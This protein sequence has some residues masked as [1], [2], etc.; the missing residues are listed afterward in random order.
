[1]FPA[2]EATMPKPS[3]ITLTTYNVVCARDPKLLMALRAMADINTDIALLTETKLCDERYAKKGHGYTVF[4]TRA[5]STQQGGVAFAWKT[6]GTHWTLEGMRAVTAN[7]VSATLVSGTH[8]WLVIGAYLPPSCSP[9]NELTAIEAEYRRSPRLPVIWLGDFNANL[10]DDLCERAIAISTTAQHLGVV[11]MLHLFPQKKYRKHTFHRHLADGAHQRSRCDYI[12][13]DPTMEV[14]SLRMVDPPRYHS[15]HVALKMQFH[16]STNQAHRRY[17]NNRSQLPSVQAAADEGEPNALFNQLLSHH[18]RPVVP[19]Y[20]TRD[21]WIAPDTWALID[22][23]TSALKRHAPQEELQPLRKEIWRMIRRDRDARLQKTGDEI[24]AHLDANDTTEAWRLVKVWYRHYAKATP[25]TPMDLQRIGK[26]YRT[27]YTRQPTPP[28]ESIRGMVTYPVADKVPDEAEIII[29]LRSLRSGR[30]PG[31]SGMTVEDLKK[32]YTDR[33]T[34]P[35]PWLLLLQLVT[36][37]F[38]TGIVPT[39]ARSNTLVL[40]PKPEPGQVRGI[41]LLEPLWKLIS[42]VIN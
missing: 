21:V 19:T 23:R 29:A 10:G 39:R 15:D 20:P 11:D 8:R 24:Q 31:P 42:A 18:E 22:Q 35:A 41:G 34:Q 40:I 4:A 13:V 1:M 16:C 38:Q 14:G 36:H 2:T 26:E 17:L 6:N 12:L 33:E 3:N 37:A 27:L 28:G 7:V 25:P 9:D 30:A 32:W 5:P